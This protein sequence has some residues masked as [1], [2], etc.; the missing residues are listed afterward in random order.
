M[1]R[2]PIVISHWYQLIEGLEASSKGFYTSVEE[3]IGRRQVPGA[4]PSRVDWP[5]GGPLS[6]RREYLRVKRNEYVID[7]C[8]APF[9]TAFFFSWWLGEFAG[10]LSSIPFLGVLAGMFK[11]KFTYYRQDT[12]LMFQEAV[13]HSVLEVIDGLTSAKGIRALSEAERKPIIRGL[14]R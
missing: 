11:G 14:G 12:Q 2:A 6:P 10:C 7:I 1:A 3:A 13:H 5:E 9:G 8:G 4:L